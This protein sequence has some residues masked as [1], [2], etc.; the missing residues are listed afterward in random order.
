[1]GDEADIEQL[2]QM[3]EPITQLKEALQQSRQAGWVEGNET[4]QI[5]Q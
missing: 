5:M 3:A 2:I 4:Q 1:M